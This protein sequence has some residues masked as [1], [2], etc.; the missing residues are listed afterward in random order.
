MYAFAGPLGRLSVRRG[1]H[2]RACAR[3]R[4]TMLRVR[5]SRLPEDWESRAH[6]LSGR[7]LPLDP[8]EENVLDILDGSVGGTEEEFGTEGPPS[9]AY[10][11]S[12]EPG[13]ARTWNKRAEAAR[14]RWKEPAFRAKMLAKRAAKKARDEAAR[15]PRIEIGCMDSITLCDDDRAK[16]INDYV[17]SNRLRSEKIT[18][19]HRDR[20]TWMET[21]LS[22]GE[23]LRWRMN[24]VEYK[25]QRQDKRQEE[26]RRRHARMRAAKDGIA[27]VE[28]DVEVECDEEDVSGGG[29]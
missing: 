21:R 9:A 24:R 15:T 6:S 13:R 3:T 20:R 8:R 1:R 26:A 25:K 18:A 5:K 16:M 27:L 7:F 22:A 19:Y 23:D 2:G 29:V 17:R 11:N 12:A 14:R 4:V 10:G 28:E